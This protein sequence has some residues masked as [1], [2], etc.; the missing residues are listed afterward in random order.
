MDI[1]GIGTAPKDQIGLDLDS[2]LPL[3]IQEGDLKHKKANGMTSRA[4]V[5]GIKNGPTK[6]MIRARSA[7]QEWTQLMSIRP[8]T[9]HGKS[10]TRRS[11]GKKP[12]KLGT[13][14]NGDGQGSDKKIIQLKALRQVVDRNAN[15]SPKKK[16]PLTAH[17]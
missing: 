1:V 2:D 4:R 13:I 12:N 5:G 14:D 3:T 6:V 11:M 17:F 16:K 10:D 9:T 15:G 8:A 7:A